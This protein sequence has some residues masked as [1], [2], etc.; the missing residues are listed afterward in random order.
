M[1]TADGEFPPPKNN[2]CQIILGSHALICS[3][4]AGKVGPKRR[5]LRQG[6][7]LG[8][9]EHGNTEQTGMTRQQ[10]EGD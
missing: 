1:T 7:L 10:A 4:V 2:S 9:I 6:K 5:N 3:C 8:T